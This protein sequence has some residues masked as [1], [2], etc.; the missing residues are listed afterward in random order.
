MQKNSDTVY[1]FNETTN[2]YT[3]TAKSLADCIKVG[4][5]VRKTIKLASRTKPFT[6]EYVSLDNFYYLEDSFGKP[7]ITFKVYVE[8][9]LSQINDMFGH[10]RGYNPPSELT[11]EED[12]KK[13]INIVECVVPEY[14]ESTSETIFYHLVYTENFDELLLEETLKRNPFRV[15]RW[16]TDSSNPWGIGIG[17]ENKDLLQ[18]L[19]DY[20][21]LRQE[22]AQ[23]IV[24]PPLNFFGN[25]D[26]MYKASLEPGAKNYAGDGT[27]QNNMGVQ[28]INLGTNLLPVEQDIADARQRIREIYMAQPLGDV[29]DIKNRSATEMSLRH[30]MFRK[31]FSGA[32]ELINTE[33]LQPTFMDAYIILQEAGLLEDYS[34]VDKNSSENKFLEFSQIVYINELTK[35]SGMEEVSNAVNWYMTNA[36]VTDEGARK[37][38][39]DIPAFN[40]W[41][42]E[43]MRVPLEL[44]PQ[45]DKVRNAIQRDNQIQQLT[46]LANVQ[47]EGLQGQVEQLAGNIGGNQ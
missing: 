25:I 35:S 31:E 45:T 18:D 40:R 33:L 5:G 7:T 2:Y 17:R 38:L 3:E 9:N 15:F 16:G 26:L 13:T 28:P 12:L 47:N 46:Q 41:S 30:E 36:Q 14:K 24:T 39:M 21:K 19:E 34:E 27:P 23:G 37:Y 20:K 8:K 43:K 10:I 44:I 11:S 42:A 32:Y 1:Q 4:T 29:G 6:Y 22:H